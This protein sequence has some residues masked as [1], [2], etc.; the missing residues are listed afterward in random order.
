MCDIESKWYYL[1]DWELWDHKFFCPSFLCPRSSVGR[2][3]HSDAKGA[4]F[5]SRWEQPKKIPKIIQCGGISIYGF[6]EPLGIKYE[7]SERVFHRSE[8]CVKFQFGVVCRIR[9]TLCLKPNLHK[10]FLNLFYM[11]EGS[12]HPLLFLSK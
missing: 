5:N 10:V 2:A 6:S 9:W 7:G 1:G 3:L 11:R 8:L 12:D 4:G